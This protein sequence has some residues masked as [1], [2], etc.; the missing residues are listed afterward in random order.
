VEMTSC[1]LSSMD[2]M[3]TPRR[4]KRLSYNCFLGDNAWMSGLLQA[5]DNFSEQR[6]AC[7]NTSSLRTGSQVSCLRSGE[8][9]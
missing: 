2:E 7:L 5:V 3:L 9:H 1:L 8:L 6:Q 4:K